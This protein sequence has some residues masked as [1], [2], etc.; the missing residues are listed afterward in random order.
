MNTTELLLH[1]FSSTSAFSSETLCWQQL[2]ALGFML[3]MF[4]SKKVAHPASRV[5][6]S[7]AAVSSLAM[8][9]AVGGKNSGHTAVGDRD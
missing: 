7:S 4:N 2:K 3:C 9:A 5:A 8:A 1:L 6:P